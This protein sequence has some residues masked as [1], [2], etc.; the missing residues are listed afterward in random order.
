MPRGPFAALPPWGLYTVA[1]APAV[2]LVAVIP[3][4]Q[5]ADIWDLALMGAAIVWALVFVGPYWR[6]LDE[7]SREAQRSAMMWGGSYGLL[8]AII[9]C[10]LIAF[11]PAGAGWVQEIAT[12]LGERAGGR[13]PDT[14]FAFLAGAMF[15]A[16][17][18]VTGFMIAWIIWWARR[19]V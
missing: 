13:A 17:V 12:R 7:A 1:M 5:L 10:T 18:S 3:L 9:D 16:V 2:L 11:S 4:V 8:A 15:T 14:S 19:S 6:R